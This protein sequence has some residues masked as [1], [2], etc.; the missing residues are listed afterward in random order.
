MR[1][2]RFQT[3]EAEINRRAQ[4]AI[5]LG[6]AVLLCSLSAGCESRQDLAQV[7]GIVRVDGAPLVQGIVTFFPTAGRSASGEIGSDGTFRLGTYGKSDGA[8]VGLHRVTITATETSTG[9]PNYDVD[10]P[11][12]AP[13]GGLVPA[14]Y[15]SPEASH[16]T[17]EVKP[18]VSNHAEL[19]LTKKER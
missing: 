17:F 14:R 11:A 1:K 3:G 15:A 13:K 9:Q 16:L 10:R 2:T 18:G 7:D 8:L 4:A 19:E 12:T 6:G 5:C